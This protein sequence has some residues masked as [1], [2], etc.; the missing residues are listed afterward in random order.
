VGEVND[1]EETVKRIVDA[2]EINYWDEFMGYM[3]KVNEDTEYVAGVFLGD[4]RI[5]EYEYYHYLQ[6]YADFIEFLLEKLY[7]IRLRIYVF[8]RCGADSFSSD[9]YE[10]VARKTITVVR[11]GEKYHYGLDVYSEESG[12]CY[13]SVEDFNAGTADLLERIKNRYRVIAEPLETGAHMRDTDN[14]WEYA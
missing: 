14:G 9:Y 11:N 2:R 5:D 8:R 3:K 12:L 1:V 6:R 7:G 13:D 4:K 10:M